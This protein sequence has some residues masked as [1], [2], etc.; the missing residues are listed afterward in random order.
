MPQTRRTCHGRNGSTN[1]CKERWRRQQH[2]ICQSKIR[3]EREVKNGHDG[4]WVAHPALV[5]VAK[6]IFDEYMPFANQ[7]DKKFPNYNITEEDL[8]QI[9]QGT[10]TENEV[11][12]INVGIALYIESWLM[13]IT[14][15]L[16]STTSWKTQQPQKSQEH[17]YGNGWKTRTT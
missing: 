15:P 2:R 11:K 9:P 10:I 3:Q 7:I 1:P 17:K 8:L 12:N 16:P 13:G 6:T 4:T 14:V 5:E